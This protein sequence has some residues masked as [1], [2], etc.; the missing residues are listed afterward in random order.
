V[1][2]PL[3]VQDRDL[4]F[5]ADRELPRFTGDPVR[6][7]EVPV[8][9]V[10]ADEGFWVGEPGARMWVKL[11]VGGE[12]GVRVRAGDVVSFRGMLVRHGPEFADRVGVSRP[13]GAGELNRTGHHVDVRGKSL[14]VR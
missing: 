7:R 2:A 9:A 14:I 3:L 8:L 12:S 1:R 6:A 10:P 13:E 4:R 5:L 11:R